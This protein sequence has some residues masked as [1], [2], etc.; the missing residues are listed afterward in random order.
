MKY[1]FWNRLFVHLLEYIIYLLNRCRILAVYFLAIWSAL[2]LEAR[3]VGARSAVDARWL[4]LR[5]GARCVMD[6]RCGWL[7]LSRCV[8]KARRCTVVTVWS[9]L[10]KPQRR[11]SSLVPQPATYRN[12]FVVV[13][14]RPLKRT[15][16]A[17]DCCRDRIMMMP[18]KLITTARFGYQFDSTGFNA[19]VL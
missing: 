13:D 18:M 2:F 17:H 6:I 1:A 8:A 15:R 10:A 16:G 3:F 11:E 9:E 5:V 14:G 7:W 12:E 19:S 4:L